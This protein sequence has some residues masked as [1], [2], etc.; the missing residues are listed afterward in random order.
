MLDG[1]Y[2]RSFLDSKQE[3]IDQLRQRNVSL[4]KEIEVSKST[5]LADSK[6]LDRAQAE[7]D[8]LYSM[9]DGK[10]VLKAS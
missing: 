8:H 5:A 4:L 10:T 2:F 6:E 9:L 3:Q 7:L 1:E